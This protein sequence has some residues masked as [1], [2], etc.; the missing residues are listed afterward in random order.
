MDKQ[1]NQIAEKMQR[2]ERILFITGAGM[3]AGSGLPVY[4]GI[5]GLYNNKDT[6]DGIPIE[7][8]LSGFSLKNRPE[9]TWKYLM[10]IEENCRK[11]RFNRGH[12]IIVEIEKRK[13]ATWV[14]TQNI[15]DY[16]RKAG[17]QN[18]IEIHGSFSTVYCTACSYRIETDSYEG[19][20]CPPLC[21]DCSAV[22]RP[23]VVLFGEMLPEDKLESLMREL[24]T[25]FDMVFSI[26]TSSVFPYIVK[27]VLDCSRQGGT[28]VEINPTQTPVSEDVTYKLSSNATDA[29]EAIYARFIQGE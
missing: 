15:D 11:A 26:G 25:G 13:A 1:I 20:A 10:Q 27:P 29:L 9:L 6:E 22:L 17:S 28:T 7:D 14:L 19:Y 5:G 24:T 8:A 12:E 23:N 21:P 16:H 3:S 2:A 4:R 18:M